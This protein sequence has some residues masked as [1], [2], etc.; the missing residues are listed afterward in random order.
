MQKKGI[1]E[2]ATA[3][4]QPW[5]Q[6]EARHMPLWSLRRKITSAQIPTRAIK[7]TN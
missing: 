7:A 6:S 4:D 5:S 2:L 3:S 1:F